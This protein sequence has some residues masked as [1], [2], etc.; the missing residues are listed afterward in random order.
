MND[1]EKKLKLKINQYSNNNFGIEN[2]DAY[3]FG[4]FIQPRVTLSRT[5]KNIIKSLIKYR[6]TDVY[7]NILNG[8]LNKYGNGLQFIYDSLNEAGRNLIIEII[9]YRVLGPR[10]VKLP[11]N[12]PGYW[13]LFDKVK[14]ITDYE[15]M[16]DPGFLHFNL[17]RTV[18]KSLGYPIDFY[19]SE[20]GVITNFIIEQY[21]YKEGDRNLVTAEYGETVLDIGGCWGDT[22]L[23]FAS[24]VGPKGKVF[25]FEFIPGNI[26]IHNINTDLNPELSKNI[27]LIKNPVSDVSDL[28]VY[29]EDKGPSSRI[30][31]EPFLEQT[32]EVKTISIDDFVNRNEIQRVDFIKMDIEGAEYASLKGAEQT[33]RKFKPKLAIAI[34]HSMDDF[35]NIPRWISD[36]NLDYKLHIGHYT[37]HMEETIIFAN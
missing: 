34:Y 9:S 36:L 29:Y 3:R 25:S 33:I 12:T 18:L 28:I 20:A 11:L 24:K 6:K 30:S 1:F 16:I 4:A 23:Y 8:L 35:V 19:F 13:K 32:G 5:I 14:E 27:R 7:F 21:A 22:A 15:D 31:F 10:R 26:R 17:N 2:H 37:I